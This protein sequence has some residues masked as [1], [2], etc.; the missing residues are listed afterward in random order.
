MARFNH[1]GQSQMPFMRPPDDGQT[2]EFAIAND[3]PISDIPLPEGNPFFSELNPFPLNSGTAVAEPGNQPYPVGF[4][5]AQPAFQRLCPPADHIGAS[6]RG[7]GAE[8]PATFTE[9]DGW[10]QL[11]VEG[12]KDFLCVLSRDG[13][14][15]Y[16][17]PSCR[18]HTGYESDSLVGKRI[19]DFIHRE[20]VPLVRDELQYTIAEGASTQ[21]Y[22]RFKK[23]D[24]TYLIF[25]VRGHRHPAIEES[26]GSNGRTVTP[27]A[28]VM[29]GRPHPRENAQLLDSFI[30]LKTQNEYLKAKLEKLKEEE[31]AHQKRLQEQRSGQSSSPDNPTPGEE[32]SQIT[33]EASADSQTVPGLAA[34]SPSGMGCG[35]QPPT[36]RP[37][38]STESHV[39]PNS[40]LAGIELM[41]S[42]RYASGERS[43]GIS[44]GDPGAVLIQ[45]GPA[46]KPPT[47][48]KEPVKGGNGNRKKTEKPPKEYECQRCG[49]CS[50]PEWRKGPNGPKTLCNACGLRWSKEQKKLLEGQPALTPT[51]PVV[52]QIPVSKE[53]A[54]K[55]PL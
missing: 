34:K 21:F 17:S 51:N 33:P 8:A 40:H 37:K 54:P 32:V 36:K 25:D 20:D 19:F 45:F 50:S 44:T 7:G 2:L 46:V 22:Y 39:D 9:Q 10:P 14:F 5:L 42:L 16:V 24:A 15:I 43:H 49:K 12:L 3:I 52:G 53:Q 11:V 48:K 47:D 29:A 6:G 18:A 55:A 27:P 38:L 23:S 4:P 13:H 35:R 1:N 28:F 41:T 30:D 31:E 26:S